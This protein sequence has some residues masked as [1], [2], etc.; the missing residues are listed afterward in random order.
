MIIDQLGPLFEFKI[1]RGLATLL[2]LSAVGAFGGYLWAA[3]HLAKKIESRRLSLWQG[4]AGALIIV[5]LAPVDPKLVDSL[6]T[7]PTAPV[8]ASTN[9]P[10]T[11]SATRDDAGVPLSEFPHFFIKLIALALIGGYAGGSL[12]ESSAS[13]FLAKRVGDLEDRTKE[14]EE[15]TTDIED[16]VEQGGEALEMAEAI[17][18][19]QK[20]SL[21]SI[22]DLEQTLTEATSL[23]RFEVANRAD[24]NRR[25]NWEDDKDAMERSLP[26]FEALVKLDEAKKAHW[27][28]ASLGYC[29]KDKLPP[30]Y[31]RALKCLDKAIEIRGHESRS[32]SIEFNRA[33]CRI[34]MLAQLTDRNLIETAN[35]KIRHDLETASRFPRFSEIIKKD[36]TIEQWL[37]ARK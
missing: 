4:A 17:L 9:A 1:V 26:I 31:D 6:F 30:D 32:G 10:T 3:Q 14:V 12:L 19:G 37:R 28:H 2:L 23:A 29:L 5:T 27:W 16:K 7:S 34:H 33:I 15:R 25:E 8:A 22:A 21:T 35:E 24:E 20:P 18:R 36:S 13:Q 11:S